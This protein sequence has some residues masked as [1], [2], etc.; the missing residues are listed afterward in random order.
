V[1]EFDSLAAAQSFEN[2]ADYQAIA[3]LR[4]K[5]ARSRVFLAEGLSP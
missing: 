5:A 2:S 1:L 4:Q 3:P